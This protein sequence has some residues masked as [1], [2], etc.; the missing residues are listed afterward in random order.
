MP[1]ATK[2]M[3][4]RHAEK[5]ADDGSDPRAVTIDGK[6]DPE[7][8]IV[9]GWQRAGAL[10]VL[11]APARGPLQSA[12][13]ATP[14]VIFATDA[15]KT[16]KSERPQE[17]I[18]PLAAKLSITPDTSFDKGKEKGLVD[19]ALSQDGVVL[20]CWQHEEIPKIANHILGNDTTA[21]QSW[22]GKRFDMVWVFDLQ[23]TGGYSLSQVPQL[24]LAGDSPDPIT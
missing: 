13:L 21:P 15:A 3:V 22:P 24:L 16:S 19:S 4:I 6:G 11:F 2:I 10:A 12:E 9:Q 7:S 20:I 23:A 14:K 8:L 5:P 1:Q 17:T 18:T